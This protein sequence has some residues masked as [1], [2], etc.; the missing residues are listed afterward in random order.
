MFPSSHDIT[1]GNVV[2]CLT[3]L[4]CLI[5]VGNRMLVVSKPH[6]DCIKRFCEMF[7]PYRRRILLRFSIG[8]CDDRILSYW[9]PNAPGYEERKASLKYAY[10]ADFRTSVSVEP[11]LDS[12]NIDMLI[13]D[14]SPYVT[15][16]IWIGTMNKFWQFDRGTDM[17]LRQAINRI[18][19]GQMDII[20]KQIYQHHKDNPLV[21]WKKE[22]KK[23]VGIP[24]S[25]QNGLDV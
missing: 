23:I 13:G 2:G 15:H 16:S 4:R 21:R 3:A 17:V 12:A 18:Q 1:P 24:V 11:M 19:Q 8:A 20:I 7:R 10:N 25:K 9:E 5:I 14:L 6:L 22:I